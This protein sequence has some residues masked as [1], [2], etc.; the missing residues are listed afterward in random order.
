MHSSALTLALLVAYVSAQAYIL[1][2]YTEKDPEFYRQLAMKQQRTWGTRAGPGRVFGTLGS[3]DAGLF[4]KAGY[5]QDIFNDARGRL[6]REAY[7]SRVLG[8]TG[9]SS[10][11]GGALDYSSK[12]ASGS[13]DV[14]RQIGGVTS[15]QAEGKGVWPLGKNSEVSAGGMIRQ[16]SLGRGRP[17]YGVVAKVKSK[18]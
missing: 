17:D 3:T 7:G 13:V 2:G 15:L 6:Q 1:P 9:D 8:A 14:S 12:H 18:F 4:G 10:H 5:R 11:V 16:E